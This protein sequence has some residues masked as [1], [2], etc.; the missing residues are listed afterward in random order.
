MELD[1]WRLIGFW[2]LVLVGEINL[3]A[4]MRLWM[5]S[6]QVKAFVGVMFPG[7]RVR[8]RWGSGYY[9]ERRLVLRLILI[10]VVVVV[11]KA[12]GNIDLNKFGLLLWNA[13][14]A[15][16]VPFLSFG[17]LLALAGP[18]RAVP[19]LPAVAVGRW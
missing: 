16:H 6:G 7:C 4:V 10:P 14:S 13:A 18:C 8:G 11:G 12:G 9:K 2:Y 5:M 19:C 15:S 17:F 3:R 1:P